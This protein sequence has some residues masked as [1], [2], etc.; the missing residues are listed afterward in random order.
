MDHRVNK[1]IILEG[2]TKIA[3]LNI[4]IAKLEQVNPTSL[5]VSELYVKSTMCYAF[6]EQLIAMDNMVISMN[7]VVYNQLKMELK[8]IIKTNT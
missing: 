5:E 7:T 2:L 1:D 4:M 6:L 8:R 3:D